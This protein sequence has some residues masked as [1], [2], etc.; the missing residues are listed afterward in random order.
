LHDNKL[1]TSEE[2]TAGL[3]NAFGFYLEDISNVDNDNFYEN[4]SD[5]GRLCFNDFFKDVLYRNTGNA[6]CVD[7]KGE[8]TDNKSADSTKSS[9]EIFSNN[10]NYSFPSVSGGTGFMFWPLLLAVLCGFYFLLRE[11][12]KRVCS[13][14]LEGIPLFKKVDETISQFIHNKK[15]PVIWLTGAHANEVLE[16]A[17]TKI[18]PGYLLLDFDKIKIDDKKPK[19]ISFKLTDDNNYL[20]QLKPGDEKKSAWSELKSKIIDDP[21]TLV[22]ILNIENN[23]EDAKVTEEKLECISS[24]VE[25]NKK[26][27]IISAIYPSAIRELLSGKNYQ[28][29][30]TPPDAANAKMMHLIFTNSA[31]VTVPLIKNKFPQAKPDDDNQKAKVAQ[32]FLDEET[33]YTLFLKELRPV[34][35]LQAAGTS[36]EKFLE[37]KLTIKAESLA[38]NFYMG[39]WRSLSSDEKFI[40]YDLAA[41]GLVNLHNTFAVGQLMNKGLILEEKEGH[42]QIF[43]RSFRHFIMSSLTDKEVSR[44]RMLHKQHSNWSNLQGPLLLIVLAVFVFL[45]IAQEGLYSKVIGVISGMAAGIPALLKLLSMIGVQNDKPTNAES[46][47]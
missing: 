1:T 42:L 34:L 39:I 9:L 32:L 12:I 19:D 31:V 10:V 26:V 24:L 21:G 36:Q 15:Q 35:L 6:L 3:F 13:L 20:L 37:D 38:N 22:V 43:N 4:V 14:G 5:D 25:K 8:L 33:R 45:A 7:R 46:K 23:F 2:N 44:L 11:V 29:E 17:K 28:E 18:G 27:I 30:E 16:R 40:L 41:D 47:K